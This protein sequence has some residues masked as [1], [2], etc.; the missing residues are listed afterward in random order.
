MVIDT[1]AVLAIL[2]LERDAEELARPIER[3]SERLMSSVSF[4]EASIVSLNR[5]GPAGVSKLEAFAAVSQLDIVGFDAEQ[6][7]VARDAY[8][9]YGKGRHPASLNFGD[10]ASYAL[11]ATR[12]LPL[13][14]KGDD[15][16]KTDV[17][18]V[19]E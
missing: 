8:D 11:A 6:A 15:F 3:A 7:R 5:R 12:A 9:R 1:S 17:R 19:V 13:L 16:A 4:L 14:F 10:C 2:Q 18:S